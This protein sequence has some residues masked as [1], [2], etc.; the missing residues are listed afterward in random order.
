MFSI[1]LVTMEMPIKTT[2]SYHFMSTRVAKIK[3]AVPNI[4]QD[5]KQLKYPTLW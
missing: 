1:S 5:M 3:M 2:M 4:D